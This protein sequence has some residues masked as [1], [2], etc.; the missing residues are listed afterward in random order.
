SRIQILD[1]LEL[2]PLVPEHCIERFL[3]KEIR[4]PVVFGEIISSFL[5][6]I[7]SAPC[8]DIDE[9]HSSIEVRRIV[10]NARAA[11]VQ[12]SRR[13]C[14]RNCLIGNGGCKVSREIRFPDLPDVIKNEKI[15]IEKQNPV[16][17]FR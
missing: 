11:P 17:R 3:V 2:C 16:D 5:R 9:E 13:R 7:I 4:A 8:I 15:R 6:D 10:R 1:V 14:K 12:S